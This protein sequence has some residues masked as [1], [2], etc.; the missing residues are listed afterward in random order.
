MK[1]LEPTRFPNAKVAALNQVHT[2]GRNANTFNEHPL[3]NQITE[4]GLCLLPFRSQFLINMHFLCKII[5]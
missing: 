2:S 1:A 3:N 5:Q 4:F